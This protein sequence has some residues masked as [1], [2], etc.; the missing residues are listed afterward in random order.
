MG[1]RSPPE[2]PSWAP[3]WGI[4][5]RFWYLHDGRVTD[6][7]TTVGLHDGEAKGARDR[8]FKRERDDL[9]DVRTSLRSL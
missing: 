1:P 6:L 3:L 5:R 4:G 7:R 8:L 2:S 9:Q